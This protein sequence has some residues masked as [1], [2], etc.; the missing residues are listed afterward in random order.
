MASNYNIPSLTLT[1]AS[2]VPAANLVYTLTGVATGTPIDLKFGIAAGTAL[3]FDNSVIPTALVFPS[4]TA[5]TPATYRFDVKA[6]DSV[7]S[8][9]ATWRIIVDVIDPLTAL[10]F[11]PS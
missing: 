8:I 11:D 7:T 3:G 10:A 6:T 1:P 2:P 9:Q 5:V 4:L